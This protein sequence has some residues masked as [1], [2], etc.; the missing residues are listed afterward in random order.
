MSE[1]GEPT[2]HI[3]IVDA[4]HLLHRCVH[5]NKND[6]KATGYTDFRLMRHVMVNSVI[7]AKKK[8]GLTEIVVATD[9]KPYWRKDVY[10]LYKSNRVKDAEINWDA[11]NAF[12]KEF[13]EEIT[14]ALPWKII[15]V[16]GA[17]AD[18]IIG[19][20]ACRYGNSIDISIISSDKDFHQLQQYS[21]VKQYG[22]IEEKYIEVHDP[23][24]A[25]ICKVLM[26]DD[27]DA[28]PNLLMDNDMAGKWIE[29]S[30]RKLSFGEK[31]ADKVY[32]VGVE[33][34]L[35]S[36]PQ[37]RENYERNKILIDLTEIPENIMRSILKEYKNACVTRNWY[38]IMAWC[39]KHNLKYISE[40][41]NLI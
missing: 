41:I 11:V 20:L 34:W 6:L 1:F 15:K 32:R 3:G 39:T 23:E 24:K 33:L 26:G 28:I 2:K 30:M 31:S 29:K 16:A 12:Y 27:G 18:D 4:S 22:P 5:T 9:S 14:A 19:T 38:A 35:E 21:R 13:I 25:L 36:N 8:L 37:Y 10:P 40:N 7:K 17:E